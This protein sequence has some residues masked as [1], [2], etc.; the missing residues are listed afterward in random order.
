MK[1]VGL[2]T[3]KLKAILKAFKKPNLAQRNRLIA[4]LIYGNKSMKQTKKYSKAY[5]IATLNHETQESLYKQLNKLGFFWDSK[6][7][8]WERDDRI[9][10]PPTDLIRIRVWAATD[11]VDGAASILIESAQQYGL[12][13]QEKTEPYKCRPPKQNESRIYLTFIDNEVFS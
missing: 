3:A 12:K 10:D 11:K 6:L 8:K 13:F 7:Q 1:A 9:A 4:L 5:E 2:S